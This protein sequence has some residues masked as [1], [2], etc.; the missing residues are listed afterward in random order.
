MLASLEPSTT[1]SQP[2]SWMGAASATVSVAN[3]SIVTMA[4]ATP[5]PT[6]RAPRIDPPSNTIAARTTPAV[7][8][9]AP[10][11]WAGCSVSPRSSTARTTVVPPYATMT[12][13][14]TLSGPIRSAVK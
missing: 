12:G 10:T 4:T 6:S 2:W 14:T 1:G 13:L 3:S 9:T 11:I 5:G 7:A 8:S